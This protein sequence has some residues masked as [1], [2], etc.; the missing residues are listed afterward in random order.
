KAST[1][2]SNLSSSSSGSPSIAGPQGSYGGVASCPWVVGG[3]SV[4]AV[5]LHV[6]GL[7]FF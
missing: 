4:L 6:R 7:G 5:L 2:F 1:Q 3:G